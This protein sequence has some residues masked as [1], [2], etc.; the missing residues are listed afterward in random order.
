[1]SLK[2]VFIVKED[3]SALGE[4]WHGTA[5]ELGDLI[6]KYGDSGIEEFENLSAKWGDAEFELRNS[7]AGYGYKLEGF[8]LWIKNGIMYGSYKEPNVVDPNS[9]EMEPID[10]MYF[11]PNDGWQDGEP[12]GNTA[13][14]RAE[15][16]RREGEMMSKYHDTGIATSSTSTGNKKSYMN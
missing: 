11:D 8:T 10:I 7:M 13:S 6:E 16:R 12:D 1:M 3:I 9:E 2:N 15:E 14:D 5:L 4:G